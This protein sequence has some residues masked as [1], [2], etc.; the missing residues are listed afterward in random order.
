VKSQRLTLI[1][2]VV[3]V[4]NAAESFA[5][6]ITFE[7]SGT[8]VGFLGGQPFNGA[9]F[10]ITSTANTDNVRLVEPGIIRLDA[11]T[12]VVSVAGIGSGEF[13]NLTANVDNQQ[14]SRVGFSDLDQNRGILFIDHPAFQSYDL[15]TSIGPLS[16]PP[17]FN[18]GWNY[19]TS[20]GNFSL[21]TVSQATFRAIAVPEPASLLL[22]G[23]A[24]LLFAGASG[25]GLKGYK[26]KGLR[27]AIKRTQLFC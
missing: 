25:R 14:F 17:H 6:P 21:T 15:T 26:R 1:L 27:E 23:G 13:Y 3:M 24:V 8:G 7:F 5:V 12:A 10:T 11:E 18:V 16:G 22:L 2:T 4:A 9:A 19:P 20:N